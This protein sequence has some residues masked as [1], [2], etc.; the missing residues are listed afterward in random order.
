VNDG[1]DKQWL[2]QQHGFKDKKDSSQIFQRMSKLS[3][4]SCWML[5]ST[6]GEH[7]FHTEDTR[8]SNEAQ[9]IVVLLVP[10]AK[11]SD[12]RMTGIV[13][14]LVLCNDKNCCW[15]EICVPYIFATG[16]LLTQHQQ[17]S[18]SNWSLKRPR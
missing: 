7:R 4:T 13:Q 18:M 6:G 17:V 11:V 8:V 10:W 14:Y 5:P 12:C 15:S 2:I 16:W 3:S 9:G 1:E